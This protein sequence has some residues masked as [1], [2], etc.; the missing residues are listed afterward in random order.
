L[1]NE[2][3]TGYKPYSDPVIRCDNDRY[4]WEVTKGNNVL[5]GIQCYGIFY[6][7]GDCEHRE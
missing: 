3:C 1:C 5:Y 4:Y 7:N 6:P 2:G